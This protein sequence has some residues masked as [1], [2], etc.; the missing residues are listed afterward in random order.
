MKKT[1]RTYRKKPHHAA[2]TAGSF[3]SGPRRGKSIRLPRVSYVS[4]IIVM[5]SIVIMAFVAVHIT[6]YVKDRILGNYAAPVDD[7]PQAQAD[8]NS[9]DE[10]ADSSG[11]STTQPDAKPG[12]DKGVDVSSALPD[13]QGQDIDTEPMPGADEVV[14]EEILD[15]E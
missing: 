10:S 3:G 7:A 6:G 11:E 2:K 9:G 5:V 14:N 8:Q 13:D 1:R 4:I 12:G 15:V